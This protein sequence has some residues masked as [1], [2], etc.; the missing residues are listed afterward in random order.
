MPLILGQERLIPGFEAN[1]LGL[2]GRRL[3]RV[4]HHL[5]RRLPGG[6]A[7]RRGRPTSRSSSASCARRS[8]PDLD[9]DFVAHAR[10]LRGPRRAARRR[11]GPPRA[12]RPRPGAPRVRRPDHRVRRRERDRRAPRHPGR[13]GGRGDARR[14]PRRRSRGRGSPRRPTSRPSTRPRPT[15]TPSSG[16]APRSASG[17]CS[18]S[19][20]SPTPRASP[21]PTPRSTAEV[22]RGRERYADDARAAGL[23][24]LRARSSLHPQH[25]PPQ[26]RRR[27]PHRRLAGR[28]SRARRRCRTSRTRRRPPVEGGQAAANAAIDATDPGAILED[29]PAAAG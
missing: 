1:L 3:D 25:A 16:R 14:V 29:V 27:G 2:A 22:A 8:C 9:D 26:P 13:P 21:S 6:R 15:C 12:Q 19:R 24:R 4:R 20:R 17:P 18:S 11:Q 23:L 5:P 7:G 10:R 28:P